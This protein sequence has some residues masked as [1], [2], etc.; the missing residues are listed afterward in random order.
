MSLKYD[1][2]D[3]RSLVT[4]LNNDLNTSQV[5]IHK[6]KAVVKKF[7]YLRITQVEGKLFPIFTPFRNVYRFAILAPRA[8]QFNQYLIHKT[9]LFHS[10]PHHLRFSCACLPSSYLI[11]RRLLPVR[12]NFLCRQVFK[13]SFVCE[14]VVCR[15]QF[16]HH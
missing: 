11:Q 9:F 6:I 1:L 7:F 2:S 5:T 10:I 12:E 16:Y 4:I 3:G 13:V 8:C 14:R 15:H